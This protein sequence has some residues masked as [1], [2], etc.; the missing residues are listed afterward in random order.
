MIAVPGRAMWKLGLSWP[1]PL[2]LGATAA[3]GARESWPR[4]SHVFDAESECA[5]RL[6]LPR[7]FRA[8]FARSIRVWSF[9]A[10]RVQRDP[11]VLVN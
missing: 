5:A 10:L 7:A 2:L 1:P 8:G 11:T 6:R 9:S 4:T 3:M